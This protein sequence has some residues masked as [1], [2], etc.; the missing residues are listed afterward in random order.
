MKK[1]FFVLCICFA[2]SLC[3]CG[4]TDTSSNIQNEYPSNNYTLESAKDV[5]VEESTAP[6]SVD[7]FLKMASGIWVDQSTCEPMGENDAMFSFCGITGGA[8][9]FGA[10]PGGYS[11]PGNV[12][13]AEK[14]GNLFTVTLYYPAGEDMGQYYEE[15]Y[16]SDVLVFDN[17]SFHFLDSPYVYT[18][19]GNTLDE[20]CK[21]AAEYVK[22]PVPSKNSN[23]SFA[24]ENADVESNFEWD[25]RVKEGMSR[26]K[27]ESLWGPPSRTSVKVFADGELTYCWYYDAYGD[28]RWVVY[29]TNNIVAAVF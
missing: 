19:M 1:V 23:E 28:Y 11:R 2:L 22:S 5:A 18:Y 9:Y 3:A 25:E 26:A 7:D 27:V 10:Y 6:Y 16:A 20:A 29:N 15:E 24:N 14:S 21:A 12:V 8:I 17:Q 4:A 13:D